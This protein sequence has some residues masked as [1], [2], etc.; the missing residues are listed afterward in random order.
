MVAQNIWRDLTVDGNP[1]RVPRNVTTMEVDILTLH[2]EPAYEQYIVSEEGALLYHS[3]KYRKLLK[4][5]LGCGDRYL[6]AAEGDRICGVLPLMYAE[7]NGV[8]VY[9]SLPYY[10]S[11]GGILSSSAPARDALLEA[12][13]AIASEESTASS[14]VVENPFTARH[15]GFKHTHTDARISQYT[16]LSRKFV[17]REDLMM[18]IDASGRRNVKK[19]IDSGVRVEIDNTKLNVLCDIHQENMQVLGGLAKTSSFFS[20]IPRVFQAGTDFNLYVARIDGALVAGLLLFYYN[21]TVEY[22]T[23]AID[24]TVRSLQPLSLILVTAMSD[25]ARMGNTRWNWG[26]TWKS[27]EGVYQFKK[28]WGAVEEE[29]S[30][31]TQLSDLSILHWSKERVLQEFPG[32]YVVP[33]TELKAKGAA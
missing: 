4:E 27:Q 16:A 10:G 12:Y 26:G 18:Q 28:K 31:Y 33:F 2:N 32:F 25:A 15:G 22:F 11:N 6:V 5:L 30:Y 24:A 1:Q 3:V 19:A 7:R 13:N 21:R 29:Y 23:P 8:R 20:L 9:N 14:T 17:N